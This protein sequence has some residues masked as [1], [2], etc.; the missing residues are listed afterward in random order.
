MKIYNILCKLKPPTFFLF[1]NYFATRDVRKLPDRLAITELRHCPFEFIL[2]LIL[3]R[4]L[5]YVKERNFK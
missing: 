2:G 4:L 5:N 1:V 3:N